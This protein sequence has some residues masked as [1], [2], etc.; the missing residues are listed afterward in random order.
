MEIFI[1]NETSQIEKPGVRPIYGEEQIG[2]TRTGLEARRQSYSI[3]VGQVCSPCGDLGAKRDGCLRS[4]AFR[5]S[6]VKAIFYEQQGIAKTCSPNGWPPSGVKVI[7]YYRNENG[8]IKI[9]IETPGEVEN[10]LVGKSWEGRYGNSARNS[11]HESSRS[12][13]GVVGN[14]SATRE[15]RRSRFGGRALRFGHRG[16]EQ[17]E[18]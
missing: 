8:Q 16:T 6:P 9:A 3:C 13:D 18:K 4:A 12:E 2:R 7:R 5:I 17:R 11:R 15:Q 1:R 10:G 14:E